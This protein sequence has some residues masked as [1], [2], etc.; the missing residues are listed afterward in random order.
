MKYRDGYKY[1][2]AET[3]SVQTGIIP[4]APIDTHFIK[5]SLTGL[6]TI[7]EGY[8]W[9][10]ASGP[11]FDKEINFFFF[12][13]KLTDTMVPSCVHDGFAQLLRMGLLA[14][15][16]LG[17]VNQLL[18]TMLRD[19]GMWEARRALWRDGLNLTHGSFADPKN[20]KPVLE[21]P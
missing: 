3:F 12:T 17:P 16:W 4:D 2:V 1:Q 18:D 9:D 13:I 8:A 5:L 20:K 10:G 15:K 21:A 19:R 14:Q 11:T 6:L 7:V